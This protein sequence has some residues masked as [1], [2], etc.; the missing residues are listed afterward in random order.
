M[1]IALI[2]WYG[3]K[4]AGD[5]ALKCV[6]ADLFSDFEIHIFGIQFLNEDLFMKFQEM[7]FIILGGGGVFNYGPPAPFN[8]VNEWLDKIKAKILIL[9]VGVTCPIYGPNEQKNIR[10]LLEHS[11]KVSVR[12]QISKFEFERLLPEKH[13]DVI[14]DLGILLKSQPFKFEKGEGVYVGVCLRQKWWRNTEAAA[15]TI[16]ETL[17]KA[18]KN[19]GLKFVFIP[20]STRDGIEDDRIINKMIIS[21]LKQDCYINIETELSPEEIKYLLSKMDLVI[22]MRLHSLILAAAE[23]VPV[24]G[25]NYFTKIRRFMESVG[26]ENFIIELGE[27]ETDYL[28]NKIND[29]VC[30]KDELSKNIQYKIKKMKKEL[31]EYLSEIKQEMLNGKINRLKHNEGLTTVDETDLIKK[32]EGIISKNPYHIGA[33]IQLGIEYEKSGDVRKAIEIYSNA[34]SLEENNLIVHYLLSRLYYKL[35]DLSNASREGILVIE[36]DGIH[37]MLSIGYEEGHQL[38]N[39]DLFL[40]NQE[41]T[42]ALH[43]KNSEIE[44]LK[45]INA[46]NQDKLRNIYQSL[47]WRMVMKFEGAIDQLLPQGT[48]RRQLYNSTLMKMR[49]TRSADSKIDKIYNVPSKLENKKDIICFPIINWDFRFQRPQQ[50]LSRFADDGHRVFYLTI[51]MMPLD[52]K[53]EIRTLAK[54]VFELK[55][56][57]LTHFNI[58]KDVWSPKQLKSL[59]ESIDYAKNRLNIEAISLV[60]FPSWTPV[61]FKLKELYG[62]KIIYDCMD[63]HTGFSNINNN[64]V[65]EE[66]RLL[67]DSDLLIVT[68][69]HLN[70]KARKYRNNNLLLLP[71]AGDFNHFNNLPNNNILQDITKPIIGYYG[72]IAE[73]FDNELIEYIANKRK[74]W[75]FVFIGRTF[76]SKIDKLQKLS[77]VRFL[78]EIDYSELPKYLYWF[79]LCIIPFKIIPLIEATHPVKFYEYLS[80]GKP[81]ISTMLPELL[82]YSDL[83]YLAN[84]NE[85]FL[86]KVEIALNENDSGIKN[87]RIDFARNNTWDTRY[88]VLISNIEQ[89]LKKDANS[90]L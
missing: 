70:K 58:Y 9:G 17:D 52:E 90:S 28:Y 82:P 29:V 27:I 7:D 34:L 75:N 73:W 81:V 60:D 86:R 57:V 66:E 89:V 1:K 87:K 85:D 50:L 40:R 80:S 79:D 42:A 22:G 64:R 65:Q 48:N 19:S 38:R 35:G 6:L 51:D 11:A 14:P 71:N 59:I 63:E 10:F 69:I 3:K 45:N 31:S 76:G 83:C 44:V 12:D 72:A 49:K 39:Q 20:F 74:D 24:I 23:G 55:L 41:L 56:N 46:E 78:G 33:Y 67:K 47:T 32:Y 18:Y 25:I 21:N 30:N 37:Q 13:I 84:D 8:N 5:E 54:N 26:Q 43:K 62:W 61:V 4:N 2:G 53:F 77:N 88:Q 36:L 68:S 15:Q 16:A